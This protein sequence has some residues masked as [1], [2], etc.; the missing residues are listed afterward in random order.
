MEAINTKVFYKMLVSLWVW[1]PT[2]T[3]SSQNSKC[4]ISLRYL[5]ENLK[6]EIEFLPADK[7]QRCLAISSII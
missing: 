5:K 6:D 1:V 7:P 2:H 4:A 3:Q